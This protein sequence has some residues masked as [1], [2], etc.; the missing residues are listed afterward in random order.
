MSENRHWTA[1]R[2]E[3]AKMYPGQKWYRKVLEMSDAQVHAAYI[4][5]R[6]R[7]EKKKHDSV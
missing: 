3:L 4:S 5:A 1:E 2:S 6:N 7:K